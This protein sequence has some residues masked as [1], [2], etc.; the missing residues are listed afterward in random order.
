MKNYPFQILLV[1]FLLPP[2]L[3]LA[4]RGIWFICD[5][6]YELGIIG[7]LI[8][9]LI[10][11]IYIVVANHILIS[12]NL[13]RVKTFYI[14]ALSAF[15]GLFIFVWMAFGFPTKFDNDTA[16][17]MSNLLLLG[18]IVLL[19]SLWISWGLLKTGYRLQQE[20]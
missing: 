12:K 1:N 16:V 14:N 8:L 11:P 10:I 18:Y 2:I 20:K 7:P 6:P 15:S 5:E 13:T 19:V 9:F 4:L 3:G 17:M